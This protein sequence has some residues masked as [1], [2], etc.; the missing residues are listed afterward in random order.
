MTLD[1]ALVW[2]GDYHNKLGDA[3]RAL[4]NDIPSFGVEYDPDIARYVDGL[5]MWV[6]GNDSWS[7]EGLRYFGPEGIDIQ[8]HR[9]VTLLSKRG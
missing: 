4:R 9:S 3:F 7:F 5:A 1:S 6:R 8:V 2:L